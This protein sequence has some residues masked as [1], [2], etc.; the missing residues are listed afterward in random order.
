[1]GGCYLL[2]YN[3]GDSGIKIP[4][5]YWRCPL[6]RGSTVLY[7]YTQC[8]VS[9]DEMGTESVAG[10]MTKYQVTLNG[11]LFMTLS[12]LRWTLYITNS[13]KQSPS[14]KLPHPKLL[15]KLPACYVTRRFTTAFTRPPVP[16][17]SQT[18]PA[19][20]PQLT[21]Q[22]SILIL[23]SHLCLGLQSGLPPSGFPTKTLYAPFLSPTCYMS[24]P[25]QS[26]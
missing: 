12:T 20:A 26:S 21:S 2:K 17:L 9:C 5:L 24:C 7:L 6:I 3:G 22:S 11:C 19:H 15:K 13:M 25:S 10:K 8:S 1:M 23:S 4:F 18:D 16:I 14:E